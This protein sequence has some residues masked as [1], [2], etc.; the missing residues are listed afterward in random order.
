MTRHEKELQRLARSFIGKEEPF[1][2]FHEEFITRWTRM[3]VDGLSEEERKE[4][5]EIY[6]WILTSIPDPVSV[7][8]AARGVIGETELRERLRRRLALS[9]PGRKSP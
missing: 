6:S 5:N 4:W 1:W 8:D 7:E 2:G 9:P 3:P